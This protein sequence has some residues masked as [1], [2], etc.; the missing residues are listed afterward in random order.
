VEEE[1]SLCATNPGF[2]E[3]LRVTGNRRTLVGW[4]RGDFS[5]AEVAPA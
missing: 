5:F 4:W 1:V 3:S 2:S